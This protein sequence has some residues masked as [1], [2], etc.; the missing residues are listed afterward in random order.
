MGRSVLRAAVVA[1]ALMVLIP[2]TAASAGPYATTVVNQASG[3]P[4]P[5]ANGN[6][7][8]AACDISGFLIPGETNYLNSELEPFVAVNP[9]NTTNIAYF[10]ASY[11]CHR[12]NSIA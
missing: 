11:L 12:Y 4:S 6:S 10:S 1:A 3:T 8:F 2:L 9:T 7:P 5:P